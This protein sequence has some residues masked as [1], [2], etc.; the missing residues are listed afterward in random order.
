MGILNKFKLNLP[1]VHASSWWLG[2][3]TGLCAASILWVVC[4]SIYLGGQ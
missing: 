2:F 3:G 1:D 4:I